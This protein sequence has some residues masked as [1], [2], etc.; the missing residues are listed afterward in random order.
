MEPGPPGLDRPSLIV[1]TTGAL[2]SLAGTYLLVLSTGDGLLGP[3][4]LLG[5]LA[6]IAG[7]AALS[8]VA[9]RRARGR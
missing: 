9:R 1:G 4:R 3:G 5:I 8:W 2:L 7:M 6:L